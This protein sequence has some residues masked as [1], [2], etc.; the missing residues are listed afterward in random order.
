MAK[1]KGRKTTAE[2]PWWKRDGI[3]KGGGW[4]PLAGRLR[5][6]FGKENEEEDYLWEYSE[7][8]MKRMKELGMT[9]LV[10]Q[11]DRGLGPSDQKEE[12][13]RAK[14]L[15]ALCHKYGLKHGCYMANTVYYESM[16]KDEPECED[17]VV[18]THDGRMV[19]YGGEQSWRWVAC[20]NS[21][22]WRARMR[23]EIDTAIHHV[24]TD[25]LHFDNLAVW[26]EP[27]SCHCEYC[28]KAFSEY[29]IKRYP[30]A[31][32][33]RR[34]FGF[35][36]LEAMCAP[37]WYLRFFEPWDAD[38]IAN[39]LMRD[40]IDFRCWTVTDYLSEMVNY[41]RKVDPEIAIDCNSQDVW[42]TNQVLIHG[43]RQDH[44]LHLVD[45][46]CIENPDV[47]PEET[48]PVMRT[49]HKMRGMNLARR[50]GKPVFTAYRSEEQ[51]A[52]NMAMS[53]SPGINAHWGY[54][55]PGKAM[56]NPPQPGVAEMLAHFR[57]HR[58]LYVDVAPAAR[59]GVWHNHE[60]LAYFS[61]DTKH[62][63]MIMEQL[64]FERRVPFSI[65][66]DSFISKSGLK[67]YD[68]LILPNVKFISDEKVE[69]IKDFVR[70][71][72][73]ALFTEH[74]ASFNGEQRMRCA[75]PL[76]ELFAGRLKC[77]DQR[78]E[79]VGTFDPNAQFRVAKGSQGA[80]MYSE[81]G[82]GRVVYLPE[83]DFVHPPRSLP[84]GGYNVHFQGCD[85]RYWVLPKNQQEIMDAVQWLYP[86]CLPVRVYGAPELFLDYIL[87]PDGS[88]AAQ[89]IRTGEIEAMAIR[90]AIAGRREPANSRLYLPEADKPLKLSW[91]K[92]GEYWETVIPGMHRH[93]VIRWE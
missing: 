38:R 39:P 81:Y 76:L 59:T 72:G 11:F 56:L 88:K 58:E 70:R 20:F 15:A 14:E 62:S 54:A 65:L 63:V 89:L 83:I 6:N 32:S 25:L 82:K 17:W 33:Q 46:M 41:A 7:E 86:D 57:R 77:S 68:L 13:D 64:L 50:M 52:W 5:A 79:E 21:P 61:F 48:R 47:K 45:I 24:N 9:T 53:G 90:A 87:L 44:Q 51:L 10:G 55:E 35:P 28:Q 8:H 19:H 78:V 26:P 16:L 34:R 67:D 30:D 3:I 80:P 93:A 84:G 73:S 18:K 49:I 40:W 75:N 92:R 37:N 43:I 4:H 36:G 74:C 22:G 31:E 29:L 27:D 1:K 60:S 42:G 12:Q 23:R 2:A 66:T 85:S 69:V 71:G 91:Q